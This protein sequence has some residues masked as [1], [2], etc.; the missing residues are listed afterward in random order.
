MLRCLLFVALLS[1]PGVSAIAQS[2]RVEH[3]TYIE[4]KQFCFLK[5]L[6]RT[7]EG[8]YVAVVDYAELY[9]GSAAERAAKEDKAGYSPAELSGI[10]IR[11]K[12][13]QIRRFPLAKEAR[14]FL[15]HDMEPA[16]VRVEDFYRLMQGETE[17]LPQYW[18]FPYRCD[19]EDEY[20]LPCT[21]TIGGTANGTS[22]LRLNQ[23]YLP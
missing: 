4:Y 8:T 3:A 20:C 16:A 6:E 5:S 18:A 12:N 1:N 9:T 17:G 13:A 22:L 14:I 10:Y 11:N 15:L 23:E 19:T 21:I 2:R 7:P